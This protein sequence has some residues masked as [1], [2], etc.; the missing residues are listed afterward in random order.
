MLDEG[1]CGFRPPVVWY[2]PD[3]PGP[4]RWWAWHAVPDKVPI[5]TNE[6]A[7]W[8]PRKA[9]VLRWEGQ[10]LPHGWLAAWVGITGSWRNF[11]PSLSFL[12]KLRAAGCTIIALDEQGRE[13]EHG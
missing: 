11:W 8:F 9:L 1:P 13:V 2:G 6:E 3:L 12:R 10:D 7:A 5:G 4:P